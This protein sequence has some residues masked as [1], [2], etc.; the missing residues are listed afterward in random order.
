MKT[1]RNFLSISIF[2]F[3]FIPFL[4]S[5]EIDSL[6]YTIYLK[7][8]SWL[9]AQI[10]AENDYNIE[11]K[12]SSGEF[13]TLYYSDIKLIRYVPENEFF[14]PKGYT[15]KF[16]GI[17]FQC[18]PVLVY[19]SFGLPYN[20]E[21]RYGN[22]DIR[23]DFMAG[24]RFNHLI[25]IGAGIGSKIVNNFSGNLYINF[26]GYLLKSK[27]SPYYNLKIGIERRFNKK[28]PF[29]DYHWVTHGYY[30]KFKSLNWEFNPT[31]GLRIS[32]KRLPTYYIGIGYS[33]IRFKA[34][35]S[36]K[37]SSDPLEYTNVWTRNF[38]FIVGIEL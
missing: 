13:N 31:V 28:N 24:F 23:I 15:G 20:D 8:D 30:S 25:G 38:N 2:V 33:F 3:W 14:S 12:F 32:T 27:Y 4:S 7:K 11:V 16:R 9:N 19:P 1:T 5:Q 34:F 26:D 35:K 10:T 6:Y 22:E 36:N 18:H 37:P 21:N 17:Y 29:Y